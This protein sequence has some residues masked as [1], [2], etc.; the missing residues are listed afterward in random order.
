VKLMPLNLHEPVC[1]DPWDDDY[2][3]WERYRKPKLVGWLEIESLSKR[4]QQQA[5]DDYAERQRNRPTA[6]IA[7]Q[8]ER[9]ER[10][11]ELVARA[12]QADDPEL[13]QQVDKMIAGTGQT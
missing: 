5:D 12:L 9:R 8:E 2:Y 1:A 11:R 7:D 3:R 6:E 4:L 13:W 10:L